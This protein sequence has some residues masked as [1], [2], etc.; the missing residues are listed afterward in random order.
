MNKL[1]KILG[2]GALVL[3]PLAGFVAGTYTERH[4]VVSELKKEAYSALESAVSGLKDNRSPYS[5]YFNGIETAEQLMDMRGKIP[6]RLA[7]DAA[8][9]NNGISGV[10]NLSSGYLL[11]RMAENIQE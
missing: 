9:N 1:K 6:L 2:I 7:S 8:F 5:D 11:L 4:R 3:T 10:T